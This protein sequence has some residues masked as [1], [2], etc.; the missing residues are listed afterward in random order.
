MTKDSWTL[1][2]SPD[3]GKRGWEADELFHLRHFRSLSMTEKIR[4]VEEMCRT[5]EALSKGARR[6]NG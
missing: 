1:K 2:E 5:A 3:S 4:A 6:K